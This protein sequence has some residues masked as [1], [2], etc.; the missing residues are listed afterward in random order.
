MILSLTKW[1]LIMLLYSFFAYSTHTVF[2]LLGFI[3]FG[4]WW[5]WVI[6]LSPLISCYA[7]FPI[8][9]LLKNQLPSRFLYFDKEDGI[10]G[11]KE[12]RDEKG[13]EDGKFMTAWA[14]CVKR[15]PAWN[16][17]LWF[18]VKKG[19]TWLKKVVNDTQE[20]KDYRDNVLLPCQIKTETDNYGQHFNPFTS[21]LGKRFVVY[22]RGGTIYW[23]W[24]KAFKKKPGIYIEW[25]LG[26]NQDRPLLNRNR[27]K[28]KG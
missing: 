12:W 7:A 28:L 26:Y 16:F 11:N 22:E 1:F 25:E 18:K 6:L 2:L 4:T 21:I 19:E 20:F 15:N 9:Y 27:K 10:Y 23:N 8:F 13:L 17:F 5:W 24:S 14:W 3:W